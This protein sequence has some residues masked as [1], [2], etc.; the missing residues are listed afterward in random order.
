MATIQQVA[1][2]AGVSVATVSRVLNNS[3]KVV[4]ETR[5]KVLQVIKELEYNPNMIGRNLRRS[6]TKVVIVLLPSISNPFYS[7][8][9][10]GISSK[11]KK[12]GYT[13]MICNTQSDKNIETEYLNFLKYKLADGAILM[14]QESE[15]DTF[16]ELAKNYPIVQ[17]SE[18]REI[19][20]A[21]YVSIDNF[22]AAYDAVK[23]LIDLGHKRI[24]IISSRVNYM[25]AIQREAGYMKALQDADL[26]FVPRLL[27]VGDYGLKSG[28]ASAAHF[29]SMPQKPTAVF[30]ISDLMAIGALK[31][32]RQNGLRIPEDMA[33][34]GFDNISFSSVCEPAL[35][36][37]SQP[38][39]KMGSRAMELLLK[40]I[41]NN[42]KEQQNV[43]LNYE[44]IVRESTR[45]KNE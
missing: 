30:A 36:T 27:K 8:I 22:A 42:Q 20:N 45:R 5:E 28:M 1:E 3:D 15:E 33:V 18:Y 41:S 2:K 14:S 19:L 25:S 37:I 43:L 34:V 17:C 7:K 44:L 29:L 12:N 26:D 9:V 16:L 24:G 38:A 10:N 23:Y 13:V 31:A 35:T 39:F 32:F 40:K 4:D 21:P 6:E 11:A